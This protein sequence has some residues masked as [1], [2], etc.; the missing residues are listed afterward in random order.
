MGAAGIAFAA[1][2][3]IA[4]FWLTPSGLMGKADAIGYAV[5]HQIGSH[6]FFIKEGLQMPMCARC[7]G[8]YIAAMITLGYL[9][10]FHNKKAGY[11]PKSIMIILALF[12]ILWLVDGINSF[13]HLFPF[14]KFLYEPLN[15]TRLWTGSGM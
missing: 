15:L 14:W 7:S 10:A 1:L 3:L 9:F 4:W 8:M 2:I 12:V 11:P 13:L 5:C 6:S